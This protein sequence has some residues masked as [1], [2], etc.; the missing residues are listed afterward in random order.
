MPRQSRLRLAGTPFHL[1]QRGHN[2]GPCFFRDQDYQR[3]L[4]DL[5]VLGRE[6]RV[7]I[8]AYVLMTNH[9]HLLVTPRERDGMSALMKSLGQSHTQ[10]VNRSR[11][12]S[13]SL[14]SG[15]FRSHLID[16]EEY[17]LLCHRY[18]ECNPVRARMVRHPGAYRWSSFRGNA[19]GA[20]DPLLT[21]HPCVEALGNTI[22]ER[23]AAYRDLFLEDL[24]LGILQKIRTAA[25][26]RT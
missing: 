4:R 7:A 10:Y 21:L 19:L 5:F 9:V 15:R 23:R 2:R 13:G 24:P 25:N 12:R 11:G 3:Y 8:H 1:I 26:G 16:T 6:H 14:W 22:A 17:L 20:P 18:G